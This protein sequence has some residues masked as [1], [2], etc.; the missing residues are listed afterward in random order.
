MRGW[1]QVFTLKLPWAS[2]T[3]LASETYVFK[4]ANRVFLNFQSA[5]KYLATHVGCN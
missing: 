2:E 1:R 4:V 3:Y 5:C